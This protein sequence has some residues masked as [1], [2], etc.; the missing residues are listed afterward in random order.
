MGLD[1]ERRQELQHPIRM[2]LVGDS[3]PASASLLIKCGWPHGRSGWMDGPG[4]PASISMRATALLGCPLSRHREM[5]WGSLAIAR[6][7]PRLAPGARHPASD[8]DAR[9]IR[10]D[11]M[12]FAVIRSHRTSGQPGFPRRERLAIGR[13]PVGPMAS[14]W[15]PYLALGRLLGL[16]LAHGDA[17]AHGHPRC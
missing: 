3:L 15:P 14:G 11:H 8:D 16:C 12:M 5:R 1:R 9:G 2:Q 10:G 4:R 6:R 7:F 13:A 17:V